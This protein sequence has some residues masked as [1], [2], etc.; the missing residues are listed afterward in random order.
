M[1][2]TSPVVSKALE[3]P[4]PRRAR[5]VLSLALSSAVLA[6]T[7][8]SAPAQSATDSYF[9]AAASHFGV[10][11]EEVMILSEWRIPPEEVPVAL[12]LARHAG[13]STD[14]L[15]TQRR[16]GSWNDLARRHDVGLRPFYVAL[17][18]VAGGGPLAQARE[19]FQSTPRDAWDTLSL[20]DA[21][22]VALVNV[23]FLSD[24]LGVPVET[25][26]EEARGAS[27]FV[28]VYTR[29]LEGRPG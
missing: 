28:E 9:R 15:V 12:E 6:G 3:A 10:P 23:G 8:V 20:S 1:P 16:S 14:A 4:R 17:P 5:T 25:V 26:V 7:P 22:I 13:V 2:A 29:L 18:P 19:A 24:F 11:V 21:Q 27:S